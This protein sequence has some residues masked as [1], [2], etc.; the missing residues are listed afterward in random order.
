MQAVYRKNARIHIKACIEKA[1]CCCA[2]CAVSVLSCH[3]GKAESLK[4]GCKL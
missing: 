1:C 3:Q 2:G 4:D